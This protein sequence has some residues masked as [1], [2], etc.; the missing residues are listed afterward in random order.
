M[1]LKGNTLTGKKP[2]TK[3]GHLHIYHSQ[4]DKMTGMEG[5]LLV[6]RNRGRE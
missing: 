5:I 3:G 4:N 2:I 6:A 1:A